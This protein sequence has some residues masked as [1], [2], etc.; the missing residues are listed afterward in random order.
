MLQYEKANPGQIIQKL[1]RHISRDDQRQMHKEF[2]EG[3]RVREHVCS[4]SEMVNILRKYAG[5]SPTR[6]QFTVASGDKSEVLR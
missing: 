5:Q 3:Y 2:N 4:Y 6:G 1:R